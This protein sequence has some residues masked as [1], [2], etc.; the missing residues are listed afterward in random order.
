MIATTKYQL[1]VKEI[2]VRLAELGEFLFFSG[3]CPYDWN[4]WKHI[5]NSLWE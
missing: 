1:K 5:V 3:E 4:E 2:W